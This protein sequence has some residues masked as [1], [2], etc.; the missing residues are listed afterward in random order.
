MSKEIVIT[1]PIQDYIYDITHNMNC[2][3]IIWVND[4]RNHFICHHDKNKCYITNMKGFTGKIFL[5]D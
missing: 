3:P 4:M 1:E 2:Y 5:E